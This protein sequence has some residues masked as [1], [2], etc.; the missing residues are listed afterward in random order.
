MSLKFDRDILFTE[1]RKWE[2]SLST[3]Q[4]N[5]LNFIFDSMEQDKFLTR[6]EWAAYMLATTKC[7]TAN[8][9]QPI[10]EYGGH[11]YFVRR[12]GSETAVGRGLGNLTPEEG[13][14]YAGDGDVQLTG[15]VNYQKAE[16]ALRI[17]YPELI[18][19]F[20]ARTG[21]KFD[22]TVGDQ[23]ND[24]AD[25]ANAGDPAIAY[26]IMSYGMRSGMFT[27]VSLQHYTTPTGFD[28]VNARRIINGLDS[29]ELI[30]GYYERW[31]V[32]LKAASILDSPAP[33]P[34]NPSP[35]EESPAPGL[36]EPVEA[37]APAATITQTQGQAS[38]PWIDRTI[39]KL[40]PWKG[41]ADSASAL[42]E[43]F[44]GV[45]PSPGMTGSSK[46]VTGVGFLK[47]GLFL[48]LGF[49]YEHWLWVVA[50]AV[51]G[52]TLW[53]VTRSKDRAASKVVAETAVAPQQSQTVV[54]PEQPAGASA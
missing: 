23:P 41:R 30:A 50:A 35:I 54:I 25:A 13:A 14:T 10:H 26:A 33:I 16:N 22:L 43:S 18:A 5:G 40:E 20:E 9:Y 2:G 4:V 6:T 36:D 27:G 28:P 12:Y 38:K 32:I 11:N 15:H 21:R 48:A 29:A 19:A 44:G 52:V 47:T 37:P 17:Q 39:E 8:T 24:Q 7:E 46:L 53:Y 1:L 3:Q 31:L 51:F 45:I 34:A 42:K 49:A